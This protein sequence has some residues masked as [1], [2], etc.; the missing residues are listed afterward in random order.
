MPMRLSP[1]QSSR[2][3]GLIIN[4]IIH[5]S[6][7]GEETIP[8]EESTGVIGKSLRIH[9]FCENVKQSSGAIGLANCCLLARVTQRHGGTYHD[10]PVA[11]DSCDLSMVGRARRRGHVARRPREEPGAS[12]RRIAGRAGTGRG[13]RR[14]HHVFAINS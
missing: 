9:T 14:V 10:Q 12:A 6:P 13:A 8:V 5:I 2:R 1:V 7:D 4:P 11:A 3:K